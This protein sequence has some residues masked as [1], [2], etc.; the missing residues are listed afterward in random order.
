MDYN[1]NCPICRNRFE[2]KFSKDYGGVINYN[3]W[4][5]TKINEDSEIGSK[6]RYDRFAKGSYM[7]D[8]DIE[9]DDFNEALKSA[10]IVTIIMKPIS[11]LII[12]KN[13]MMDIH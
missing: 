10:Y 7:S 2:I 9:T 13:L 3:N 12:F 6:I 1:F 5:N 8:D 4:C 11:L